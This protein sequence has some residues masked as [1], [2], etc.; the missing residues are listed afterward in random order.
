MSKD[1]LI[2]NSDLTPQE[3]KV[4]AS[5]AGKASVEARRRKKT[6]REGLEWLLNHAE[7]T[8]ALKAKLESEG[9]A[10]EDMNHRMVILRSLIAKAE[11]GDV[12]A[13][14]AIIAQ[15]GEKPADKL[16]LGGAV[17]NKVYVEYLG[18]PGDDEFPSSEAEVDAER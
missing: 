4:K 14:N 5:I 2:K 11:A 16:D 17:S 9:I 7:L 10:K 3:R 18:S 15:V 12:A 1:N 8:P 13:Y 6:F